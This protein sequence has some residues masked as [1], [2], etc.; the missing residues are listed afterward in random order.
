MFNRYPEFSAKKPKLLSSVSDEDYE[1]AITEVNNVLEQAMLAQP[2][3]EV[4]L[5]SDV[6]EERAAMSAALKAFDDLGVRVL[7]YMI[8]WDGDDSC[9][10]SLF[11]LRF[12]V[13]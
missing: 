8:S 9:D 2:I 10:I 11:V 13:D 3:G 1:A 12:T 6:E 4:P 7:F 5:T